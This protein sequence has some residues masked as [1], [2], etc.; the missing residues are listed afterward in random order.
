MITQELFFEEVTVENV[1]EAIKV[2]RKIFPNDDGAINIQISTDRSLIKK[3]FLDESKYRDTAK[4]WLC[5]TGNGI[6]GITGIYSY[7]EYPEDAWLGWFG[8][9]SEFRKK[10]LGREILLWTMSQAKVGGFNT[11]RLYTDMEDDAE[12]VCLYR[13]IGMIEEPYTTEDLDGQ[14][15]VFSKSLVSENTEKLGDK[16]LFL[17][18]QEELQNISRN[19]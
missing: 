6:V 14:T 13:K 17:K 18:E 16:N 1:D 9:L 8:V 12:A 11:F 19:V 3:Y 2:Q 10:G 15:F 7:F 4:F 5:R